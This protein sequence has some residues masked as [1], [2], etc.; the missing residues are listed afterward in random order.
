MPA[1]A[2]RAGCSYPR[3]FDTFHTL[4]KGS[5]TLSASY[6]NNTAHA[7]VT[8]AATMHRA[9]QI[10]ERAGLRQQLRMDTL[11]FIIDLLVCQQERLAP[12][13]ALIRARSCRGTPSRLGH[14]QR[15]RDCT[16]FPSHTYHTLR[17]CRVP[18]QIGNKGSCST[19]RIASP[20]SPPH[21]T[22]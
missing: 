4:L 13:V 11:G 9:L 21:R 10:T 2:P 1:R 8:H 19:R 6:L 5:R 15:P 22:S 7:H 3:N 18:S 16:S 20:P 14:S 12:I 17:S